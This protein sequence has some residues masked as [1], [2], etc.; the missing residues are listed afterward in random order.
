MPA[1]LS[2]VTPT[3]NCGATIRA[4]LA[5]VSPLVA[6]GAEHLVVDSG[7]TD[8]TAELCR[9]AG[10]TVLAHPRGNLY[11][12]VNAGMRAARGEWLT[13][14]NGDDVLYAD[15]VLAALGAAPS[16]AIVY[17]NIETIDGAGRLVYG[18]RTAPPWLIGRLLRHV[19]AL[20][21][22]GTLVS[23][24]VFEQLGGFDEGLRLS[25]DY[26]FFLRA[27]ARGVRLVKYGGAPVAG[28]R[29]HGGQL[30]QQRANIEAMAAEG[31]RARARSGIRPSWVAR[32]AAVLAMKAVNADTILTRMMRLPFRR[33]WRLGFTA[34]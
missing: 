14:I 12:A 27:A 9:Q 3:L 2:I 31:R 28:F 20:H 17:G 33:S 29:L 25:S 21:Q 19:S 26:D 15:A 11:A 24:A 5:S 32:A 6:A 18:W 13:Y 23:R 1:R 34:R 22:H 4:T 30:S 16:P 10:A 8:G 7:S